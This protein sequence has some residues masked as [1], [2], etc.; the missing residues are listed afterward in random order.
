MPHNV[1]TYFCDNRNL[2]NLTIGQ[3]NK[4]PIQSFVKEN[5]FKNTL[6]PILIYYIKLYAYRIHQI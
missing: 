6:K 4:I 1:N 5:G 2:C 3:I